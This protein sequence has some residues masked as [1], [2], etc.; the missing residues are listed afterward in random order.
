MIAWK[1][2]G[3]ALV[4]P[5]ELTDGASGTVVILGPAEQPKNLILLTKDAESAE[6]V[7]TPFKDSLSRVSLAH[8][9]EILCTQERAF[10]THGLTPPELT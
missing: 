5:I 7:K 3:A 6:L 2:P 9:I 4:G 8:I 1:K 10:G